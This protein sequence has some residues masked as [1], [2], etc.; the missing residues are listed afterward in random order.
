MDCTLEYMI[1]AFVGV[2]TYCFNQEDESDI[3]KM[4]QILWSFMNDGLVN[5]FIRQTFSNTLY[6]SS[7]RSMILGDLE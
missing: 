5:T 2:I 7:R 3:Q 6:K 4:A 1:S